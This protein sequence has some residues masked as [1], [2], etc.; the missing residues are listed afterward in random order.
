MDRG[1]S[2]GVLVNAADAFE[3]YFLAVYAADL[4]KLQDAGIHGLTITA[5]KNAVRE[6]WAERY[7][8]VSAELS[9]ADAERLVVEAIHK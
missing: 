8:D 9:E 2:E 6:L 7:G 3:A 1:E 5:A 4:A